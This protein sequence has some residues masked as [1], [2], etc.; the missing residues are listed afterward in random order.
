MALVLDEQQ[1][2]IEGSARD[3]ARDKS[4][5]TAFRNLRDADVS[6]GFDRALWQQMVELGW[7]GVL[8]PEAYDGL[9]LDM[10][11]VAIIA[12][13]LGRTLT[14]SPLLSTAVMGAILIDTLGSQAQKQQLLPSI[15]AGRHLSTF[16]HDEDPRHNPGRVELTANSGDGSYLLNGEK[17]FVIDGHVADTLLV[18]A[19]TSGYRD[20]G[21]GLTVFV[22]S[23]DSAGVEVERLTMVDHR[24]LARIRLHDVRLASTDVLG[25]E[26]AIGRAYEAIHQVLDGARIVLAAEMLGGAERLFETTLEYLKVREQFGV[27]IGSF[28]ALKH[29]M[30]KM[31]AEVEMFESVV[32]GAL[33][34]WQ[35]RSEDLASLS[36]LAKARANDVF[37]DVSSEALQMHGGIGMTD[38]A[39]IGFYLKRSRVTAQLLG[40]SVFHRDRYARLAG[41]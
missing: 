6:D 32:M 2:L 25:G 22:V 4:P 11:A 40:D 24:N 31:F 14:A 19:R 41:F 9:G 26:Q 13:E 1:L 8:I 28:Q 18:S 38:D 29:R 27:L 35:E 20:D 16:A 17:Q 15:A 12:R 3:F 7:S 5:V 30:A 33:E 21:E 39:D 23:P 37:N 36:S 34:A 10:S